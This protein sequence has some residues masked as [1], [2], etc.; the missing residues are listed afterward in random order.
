VEIGVTTQIGASGSGGG[1]DSS[2]LDEADGRPNDE[3]ER[4]TTTGWWTSAR[5]A[6]IVFVAYLVVAF[7]VLLKIGAYRWFFSDEWAF[8][9]GRSANDIGDLFRPYTQHW[10]AVPLLW[11]KALFSVFGIKTYAPYQGSV[12]LLHLAVCVLLRVV[13]RRSGVGPWM[14][15]VAASTFVLFGPAEDDIL[16]AFQISFNLAVVFGLAQLLLSDHPGRIDYR[17]WLGLGAG[18]LAIMSSGEGPG[19]V[20]AVGVAVL[21]KRGWKQAAFQTVPLGIAF[22][23]W[24]QLAGASLGNQIDPNNNVDIPSARPEHYLGWLKTAFQGLIEG[25]A[26]FTVLQILLVVLLVGGW[27]VASVTMDWATFRTRAA[28]PLGLA[29]GLLVT[30]IAV[31]PQRYFLGLDQ[32]RSSRYLGVTVALSLPAFAF[33]ADTIIRRW[34]WSTP[35][36]FA[37]FLIPIPW[38]VAAFTPPD[39]QIGQ[40][41]FDNIKSFVAALPGTSYIHQMPRDVQPED[42][43][44]G[45]P[46]MTVGWVLDESAAGKFPPPVTLPPGRA[47]QLPVKLG[48]VPVRGAP[49][50]GLDC[51][52]HE[53]P[54][55]LRPKVGDV[56]SYK[57]D[58]QISLGQEGNR[59]GFPTV[60]TD[61]AG[62]TVLQIALP[63]LEL[64]VE[65]ARGN[66]SFELCT[67]PNE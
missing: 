20:I 46:G 62:S 28:L 49:P 22:A 32:A 42:S 30:N 55:T 8:L 26:H 16:W 6:L 15:T 2:A 41:Y 56:L 66:P 65:T 10:V 53:Q 48:V 59:R 37:V 60:F 47:A 5:V 12:I 36:V 52:T 21:M 17:D 31:V 63:D 61:K 64:I 40:S 33:A 9:S 19:L 23:V 34:R 24:Y 58:L 1:R 3:R 11:Y 35:A 45:E 18:A 51:R 13:M 39:G 27:I 7:A 25:L 50:P 29:A 44:F 14:A 38:N 54:L 67:N 57:G 4:T 43:A